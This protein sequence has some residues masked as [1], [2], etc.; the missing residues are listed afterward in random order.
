MTA[1]G[2]SL[3]APAQQRSSCPTEAHVQDHSRARYQRK[4]EEDAHAQPGKSATASQRK[5]LTPAVLARR[6]T[7]WCKSVFRTTRPRRQA[8]GRYARAP[9]PSC[10]SPSYAPSQAS[11]RHQLSACAMFAK[12]Q[13]PAGDIGQG[14]YWAMS[15]SDALSM[16]IILDSRLTRCFATAGQ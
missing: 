13:R 12:I 14:C 6:F 4:S 7:T 8:I 10:C 9:S 2:R 3:N 1:I 16:V 11:I 15:V 5:A